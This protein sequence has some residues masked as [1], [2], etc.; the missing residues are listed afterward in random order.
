MGYTFWCENDSLCPF[1]ERCARIASFFTL[2][3]IVFNLTMIFNYVKMCLWRFS[4]QVQLHYEMITF[5]NWSDVDCLKAL[6][7][8]SEHYTINNTREAT[9]SLSFPRLFHPLGCAIFTVRFYCIEYSIFLLFGD[10]H[11]HVNRLLTKTSQPSFFIQNSLFSLVFPLSLF[12]S[13]R[14][15]NECF[16]PLKVLDGNRCNTRKNCNL[17]FGF[18]PQFVFSDAFFPPNRIRWSQKLDNQKV[19]LWLGRFCKSFRSSLSSFRAK[20]RSF[21]MWGHPTK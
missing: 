11:M 16:L 9:K 13:M 20:R 1:E 18:Y 17:V 7:N 6:R 2:S 19:E 5:F 10:D 15:T 8:E 14:C 4:F 3:L 21:G 12:C